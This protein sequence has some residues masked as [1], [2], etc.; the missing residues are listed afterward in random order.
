M[1]NNDHLANIRENFWFAK[2][3]ITRTVTAGDI[4]LLHNGGRNYCFVIENNN[5]SILFNNNYSSGLTI[6]VSGTTVTIANDWYDLYCTIY[7]M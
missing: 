5:Y 3:T 2:S 7:K 6:T 4:V 1:R